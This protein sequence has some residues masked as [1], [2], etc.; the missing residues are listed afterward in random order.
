MRDLIAALSVAGLLLPEALAYSSIA[1]LPAQ[2][3]VVALLAGLVVY[4]MLGSSRFAVVAATS[5]SAALLSASVAPLLLA[6]AG[7][8]MGL[9]AALVLLTGLALML[10][11]AARLGAV[12]GLVA[13]PVLR[14][15]AFG[16]ALTI[17]IH[18][19]P[20]IVAL[21]P[22]SA[23][24]LGT[25]IELA[26]RVREWHGPS[27][28]LGLGALACL[29]ALQRWRRLPAALLVLGGG[30][31]LA[32]A[33]WFSGVARVGEIRLLFGAPSVPELSEIAWLRLGELAF[34]MVLMLFAESYASIRNAALRHGDPFMPDR[35]LLALGAA[36]LVSGLFQGMPVA[37]GFSATAANE[38]SDPKTRLAGA[39]AAA[40]VLLAVLQLMPLVA[41]IPEP[42]LAAV[43]V[44]AV[45]HS[46]NPAVFK[47]YLAWRRDRLVAMAAVLAVLLLGVLDGLLV[48]VGASLMLALRDLSRAKVT[49]LVR[50]HGGH[51]FVDRAA[52]PAEA[53]EADLLILRPEAPLFFASADGL[54]QAIAERLAAQPGAGTLILSLEE[55]PD[56]DSSGVEALRDLSSRLATEGRRLRLTRVREPVIALLLRA[57]LP[58]LDA[59]AIGAPS[60][61]DAVRAA[62]AAG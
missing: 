12:S 30:V 58:G 8:R 14:G 41:W 24:V 17:V 1:H 44:H 9:S 47:P 29:W 25:A 32:H 16:L 49:E 33:P 18:Q 45:S 15:F 5:S 6:N 48:A 40:V 50:L 62:R 53:P 59:E 21:K 19:W 7:S 55:S 42:V 60:V 34:A 10:A 13:R 52:H 4:A 22:Q 27:V 35:D 61:D 43:V 23:Q 38:A 46:L 37:A 56:L 26:S 3:G 2:A 51:A 54:M 11:A 31:A 28:V 39:L 20:V 36:N 57:G